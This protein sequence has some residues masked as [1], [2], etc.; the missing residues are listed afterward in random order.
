[1]TDILKTAP[2]SYNKQLIRKGLLIAIGQIQEILSEKGD[3]KLDSEMRGLCALV[4]A[5]EPSHLDVIAVEAEFGLPLELWPDHQ[6]YTL[7]EVAQ[8]QQFRYA[9]ALSRLDKKI[10]KDLEQL[11]DGWK[12]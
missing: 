9:I 3:N 1:M 4:R 12:G 7:T 2:T 5:T 8:R 11:F 10:L 6:G